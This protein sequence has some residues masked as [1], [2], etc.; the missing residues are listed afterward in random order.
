MLAA[1]NPFA[2]ISHSVAPATSCYYIPWAVAPLALVPSTSMQTC[3]QSAL[4][5]APGKSH[6]SFSRPRHVR[7]YLD[8]EPHEPREPQRQEE[9]A[10]SHAAFPRH[11]TSRGRAAG[12]RIQ[13][14]SRDRGRVG[15]LGQLDALTSRRRPG[16][17]PMGRG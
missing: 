6:F 4:P 10:V 2:A 11:Q 14:V 9:S 13:R 17:S 1:R 5:A 7:V 12:R 16:R 3:I 8:A 15:Y